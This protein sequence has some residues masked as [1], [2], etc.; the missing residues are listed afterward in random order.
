[1]HFY[2]T[3]QFSTLLCLQKYWSFPCL[4][5]KVWKLYRKNIQKSVKIWYV[6]VIVCTT[7]NL[8]VR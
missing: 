6:W 3:A 2:I 8:L 5:A 4:K 7:M 1:M